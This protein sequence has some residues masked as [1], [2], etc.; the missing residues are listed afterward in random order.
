MLRT[1]ASVACAPRI[2]SESDALSVLAIWR[3]SPAVSRRRGRPRTSSL[4]TAA[5]SRQSEAI[6]A[7]LRVSPGAPAKAGSPKPMKG[8]G[9]LERPAARRLFSEVRAGSTLMATCLP[10]HGTWR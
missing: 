2:T 8:C 9:A 1:L 10:S 5:P 3:I 6:V 7:M 4:S